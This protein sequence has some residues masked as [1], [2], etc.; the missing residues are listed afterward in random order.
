MLPIF[1]EEVFTYRIPKD[2]ELDT[3]VGKLVIAPFGK[4]K[5][6]LGL[7]IEDLPFFNQ[8]YEIRELE[9]ILDSPVVPNISIN[10]WKWL[11][12]YY[13]IAFSKVLESTLSGIFKTSSKEILY[14]LEKEDLFSSKESPIAKLL[15]DSTSISHAALKLK[16]SPDQIRVL[17]KNSYLRKQEELQDDFKPRTLD[18]YFVPNRILESEESLATGFQ[19][20]KK[21]KVQKRAFE[22]LLDNYYS[23]PDDPGLFQKDLDQENIS[24]SIMR[25]MQIKGLVEKRSVIIP[26][27][28][29]GKEEKAFNNSTFKLSHFSEL[30]EYWETLVSRINKVVDQGKQI[31][32]LCPEEA[33]V[34]QIF[35]ELEKNEIQTF[36]YLS[37]R[38]LRHEKRE[39]FNAL[40]EGSQVCIIGG[41]SSAL[42]PYSNLGLVI[43]LNEQSSFYKWSK[44]PMIN[45]KDA[46]IKLAIE[47]KAKLVLNS[48]APS[49]D[50]MHLLN[51]RR[52]SLYLPKNIPG[53]V[54]IFNKREEAKKNL[55]KGSISKR[56]TEEIS[57]TCSNQLQVLVIHNRKGY[58]SYVECEECGHVPQ[59]PNCDVSLTYHKS[60][61]RLKCRYCGHD[62]SNFQNCPNGHSNYK[63]IGIGAEKI[64]E[65]LK[66]IFPKLDVLR[67]DADRI[68]SK[69]ALDKTIRDFSQ[70]KYDILISTHFAFHK[71][72]FRNLGLIVF[73]NF[74]QYLNLPDFRNQEKA[75]HTLFQVKQMIGM[76]NDTPILIQ[77]SS[78]DSE[79]L[80]QL[81]EQNYDRFS[82]LELEERNTWNYPPF[83]RMIKVTCEGPSRIVAKKFMEDLGNS[84]AKTF[85]DW[86]ILGPEAP[87]IEKIRNRYLQV[88]FL[89]EKPEKESLKRLK[90]ILK[91]Q[92][93]SLKGRIDKDKLRI[94]LDVD[95]LN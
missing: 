57:K 69:K 53:Q 85:K 51:S 55:L 93:E 62:Q 94:H 4:K 58:S 3:F 36:N 50:T 63:T 86:Q 15:G 37:S 30:E 87:G 33:Q 26:R 38:T 13:L 56:I 39:L 59:C 64:E 7:V 25:Q 77:S 49:L 44:D 84:L 70:G 20:L 74:D 54:R 52:V 40:C 8:E 19:S 67:L 31:L 80:S 23:Q 12:E 91:K 32:F 72:P 45:F 42:L 79:F 43:I 88:L 73:P 68:S 65:E 10:F 14:R 82:S 89:K 16:A 83:V 71:I 34:R 29:I 60:L 66:I 22:I 47:H 11:S 9:E 5:K 18:K 78:R 28:R 27:I 24:G 92:I 17:I 81:M 48:P 46:G 35:L 6:Y 95:P 1:L 41:P 75:F 61:D 21:A 76:K 2:L 90:S